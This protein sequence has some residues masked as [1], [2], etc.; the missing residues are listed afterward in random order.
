MNLMH[1]TAILWRGP[2]SVQIGGDRARHVRLDDLHAS[3]QLWLASQARPIHASDSPEASP[4]LLAASRTRRPTRV[5][6]PGH[7]A[8]LAARGGADEAGSPARTRDSAPPSQPRRR[9]RAR[10]ARATAATIA[11]STTPAQAGASA[12]GSETDERSLHSRKPPMTSTETRGAPRRRDD[13]VID[14]RPRPEGAGQARRRGRPRTSKMSSPR[15]MRVPA[16][17]GRVSRWWRHRGSRART[18]TGEAP[19]DTRKTA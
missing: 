18:R 14:P 3:D 13:P 4:D 17:R 11:T 1:H 8:A 7:T 12:E 19:G 16:G 9:R 10:H 15:R 2:G 6:R 5:G